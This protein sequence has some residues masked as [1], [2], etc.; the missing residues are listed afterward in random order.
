MGKCIWHV[1]WELYPHKN[2]LIRLY[3]YIMG[4]NRLLQCR[5]CGK[6]FEQYGGGFIRDHGRNKF[7]Q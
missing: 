1:G 6:V 4:K 5:E 2:I 3:R 7:Y